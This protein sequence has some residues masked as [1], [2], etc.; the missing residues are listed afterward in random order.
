MKKITQ[1]S[2]GFTFIELLVTLAIV[3]ILMGVAIPSM[4]NIISSS[5]LTTQANSMVGA[6][7]VARSEAAK[8]NKIIVVRKVGGS[9]ASGWQ[10]FEDVNDSDHIYNAT[11]DTDDKLIQTYEAIT[12]STINTTFPNY[13]AYRPDGRSNLIGGS[14]YI[15]SPAESTAFRRIVI[16]NSGR[17]RTETQ[18]TRPDIKYKDHC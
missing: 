9:W 15:C 6:L 13:I 5:R 1:F 18:K 11:G 3:S 17:I 2:S 16:A 12:G 10:V 4:R 7:T 14:F 8:R